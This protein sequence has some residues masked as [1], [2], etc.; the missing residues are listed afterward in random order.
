MSDKVMTMKEAVRTYVKP[1]D[2]VFFSG[3]QHGEPVAAIHEIIRQRIGHLTVVPA[4]TLTVGLLIAEGLVDKLIT[5]FVRD[6]FDKRRSYTVTKAKQ[7]GCYPALEEHSHF[8]LTLALHAGELG[9]SFMPTKS[10]LGS[11]L[12]RHNQNITTLQC[13]FTGE[14]MAAVRAINPDVG[15][16]HVQR[17]DRDGN[18]QKWGSLGMDRSGINASRKIIVTTEQIVDSDVIRSDPNRTLVPGVRVSAVVEEPWGA[19]PIHLAGCYDSDL[20][21]YL[22]GIEG[23]SAETFEAYMREFVYGV[24]SRAEL[25]Q[26][27][28]AR[29][30]EEF[31]EGLRPKK[32]VFSEPISMGL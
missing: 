29:K 25:I 9:I 10:L 31:F 1:G 28:M 21:S 15:I 26:K 32:T 27:L 8:G 11:D 24:E 13:P 19:Y 2:T 22:D 3:M 14:K 12:A 18:A 20:K 17:A 23:G 6:L 30:G 7:N 5:A 4:L 16:L